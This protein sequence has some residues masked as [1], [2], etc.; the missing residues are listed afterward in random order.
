MI[1]TFVTNSTP[2]PL[3]G[4]TSVDTFIAG[5]TPQDLTESE[6][7]Y[8]GE[9]DYVEY[10]FYSSDSLPHKNDYTSVL[11]RKFFTGESFAIKV[12]KAGVYQT[13]LTDST[14]GT[15]YDFGDLN[16]AYYKGII[17]NWG[18]IAAAFG[19][20]DY[21]IKVE[22]TFSGTTTTKT[23][24][25][26]RVMGYSADA[27]HGTVKVESYQNGNY[28]LSDYA[29]RDTGWFTSLRMDGRLWNKTPM[30]ESAVYVNSNR[31][32][33]QIYDKIINEYTLEMGV[34]PNYIAN[35][36]I[37]NQSLA[38]EIYVTSYD[39]YDFDIARQLP[40]KVKSIEPPKYSDRSRRAVFVLKVT[41]RLDGI[42]K[43]Y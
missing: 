39:K 14:Y 40:I 38:N 8:C 6:F 5:S 2:M 3:S 7:C 11:I 43:T 25:I 18:L 32:H 21:T 10:A 19:D 26:Y 13:A 35:D 1:F 31:L 16:Y 9:C 29:F 30:L 12:Y 17:I 34:L 22:R 15:F 33:D 41:D 24:H 28:I 37:Y 20:G 23:S 36:V 42:I 27:A 4:M